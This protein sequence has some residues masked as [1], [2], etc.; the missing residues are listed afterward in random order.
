MPAVLNGANEVAVAA[1]LDGKLSFPQIAQVVTETMARMDYK[2]DTDIETI[3]AADRMA[4]VESA[5]V[6]QD[7]AK[8]DT[9]AN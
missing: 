7:V 1:F 9:I 2:E 6:L 3:L 5:A 4:R 8:L